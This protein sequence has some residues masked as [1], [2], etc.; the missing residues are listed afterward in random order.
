M[1]DLKNDV[2]QYYNNLV[3]KCKV[4]GVPVPYNAIYNEQYKALCITGLNI[5]NVIINIDAG[6][7]ILLDYNLI[8]DLR[9]NNDKQ[10]IFTKNVNLI[11][12][13]G[14]II[15][16]LEKNKLKFMDK[17]VLKNY[18]IRGMFYTSN[19]VAHSNT[20]TTINSLS[21]LHRLCKI[22][23][24]NF[25]NSEVDELMEDISILKMSFMGM[26]PYADNEIVVIANK[27]S[28]IIQNL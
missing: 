2:M 8:K 11:C 14:H 5:S 27:L 1:L 6:A 23:R 12:D 15:F 3:A 26:G 25:S 13:D 9:Y 18:L 16:L 28:K 4:L 17:S 20:Q 21:T 24:N 7:N 19:I 22:V 10:L